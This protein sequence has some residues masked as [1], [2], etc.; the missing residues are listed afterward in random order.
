MRWEI[1]HKPV[2]IVSRGIA[3]KQAFMRP[4]EIGW[5]ACES[6]IDSLG[7]SACDVVVDTMRLSD[8]RQDLVFRHP[9]FSE[10]FVSVFA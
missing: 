1:Q 3:G 7:C 10:D 8:E 5:D 9:G 6:V 4:F 2:P